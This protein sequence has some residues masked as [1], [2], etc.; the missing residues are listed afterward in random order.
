MDV[1][2][3]GFARMSMRRKSLLTHQTNETSDNHDA[4][5][6]VKRRSRTRRPRSNRRNTLAGTDS[7]EIKRA[8]NSEIESAI[9]N[10]ETDEHLSTAKRTM[11]K[12]S[13]RVFLSTSTDTLGGK[14]VGAV[15]AKWNFDALKAWG[16]SRLK[17]NN[18]KMEM[19]NRRSDKAGCKLYGNDLY[20]SIND[21]DM[22]SS[23]SGQCGQQGGK[24]K[25]FK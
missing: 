14:S 23:K 24:K 6:V 2:G 1:S 10:I 22:R 17:R 5:G 3:R 12:L 4:I 19:T 11:P 20:D 18:S 13:G 15:D 7:E 25:S 16:R 21:Q 8:I 9:N